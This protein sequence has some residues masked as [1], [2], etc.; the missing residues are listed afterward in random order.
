MGFS[1][2]SHRY[3]GNNSKWFKYGR[4]AAI[5]LNIYIRL[6]LTVVGS[7]VALAVILSAIVLLTQEK[8]S[9]ADLYPA[10]KPE[11]DPFERLAV[12][13]TPQELAIKARAKKKSPDPYIPAPSYSDR[14]VEK[15]MQSV[16]AQKAE[17]KECFDRFLK[18][19]Q[20]TLFKHCQENNLAENTEGG[21][22]R[23]AYQ[24]SIHIG[25]V[26]EALK[27]CAED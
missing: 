4:S 12:L 17:K 10:P 7:V 8:P 13:I 1:L 5:K 3:S 21:C 14:Q 24:Y 15:I 26:E 23:L 11:V 16:R 9:D 25:V 6:L 19:Y 20:E 22:E 27:S 2:P 18:N